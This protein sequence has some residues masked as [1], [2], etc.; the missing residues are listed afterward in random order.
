MK[1]L[2]SETGKDGYRLQVRKG[3]YVAQHF[4]AGRW[5]TCS[6]VSPFWHCRVVAFYVTPE[7]GA[8]AIEG[9][10]QAA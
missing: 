3:R 5:E 2:L 4:E 10:K 9:F 7:Q 6:I 8:Q 1:K